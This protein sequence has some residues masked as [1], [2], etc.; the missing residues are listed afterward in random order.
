MIRFIASTL[1]GVGIVALLIAIR[2]MP[3][4]LVAYVVVH[5][6]RKWW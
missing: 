4:L 5:F 6:L 3:Y 2:F 1:S